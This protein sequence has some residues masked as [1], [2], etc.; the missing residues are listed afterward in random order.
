[1]LL[2]LQKH[3]QGRTESSHVIFIQFPLLLML[4]RSMVHL[5][6]LVTN[7]NTLLHKG[8]TLFTLP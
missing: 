7:T 4:Y 3:Y 2:H 5:S 8:H 1:M 6:Q